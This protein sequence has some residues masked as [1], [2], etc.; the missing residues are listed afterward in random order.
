MHKVVSIM[1]KPKHKTPGYRGKKQQ[2]KQNEE[3]QIALNIG[4]QANLN[5]GCKSCTLGLARIINDSK[6]N[7]GLVYY[8]CYRI[9]ESVFRNCDRELD[10]E[11]EYEGK[12][13]AVGS[14]G[15]VYIKEEYTKLRDPMDVC[16]LNG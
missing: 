15:Y 4:L 14:D 9:G 13:Y 12:T 1:K 3:N 10:G 11:A 5:T 6:K 8:K 7:K 16:C 2:Q